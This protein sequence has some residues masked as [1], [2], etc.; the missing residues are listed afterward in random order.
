MFLEVI[1]APDFTPKA[2]DVLQTK[3]NL[4]VIRLNTS[5]EEYKNHL[6]REIRITPFGTL[7]QDTD[8]GE[9]DKDSFKVVTKAK[10][11]Q[12]MVEDMIF[13]W[14]IAKHAKSNAIVVAKDFKAICIGQGQ[15][16]RVDAF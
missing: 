8:K 1:I 11:T 9:L 2:L 13:A 16:S 12:E 14:K 5:L 15:T 10:P 6:N 7:V 3:K 4:R